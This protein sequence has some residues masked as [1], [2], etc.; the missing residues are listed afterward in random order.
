MRFSVWLIT[1]G[2][3]A[4][5]LSGCETRSGTY[6]TDAYAGAATVGPGA[7]DV[8]EAARL[9]TQAPDTYTRVAQNQPLNSADIIAMAQAGVGDDAIIAQIHASHSVYHLSSSDIIDTHDAGVSER[10]LQSMIDS[11]QTVASVV[12]APPPP[13]V[14]TPP[15]PTVEEA[16]P[17]PQVE[18]ENS[19]PGPGYVWVG[20]EWTWNG[21]WVWV[22]GHWTLP[23]PGEIAW[24][25][26]YWT[27]TPYG[28]HRVP[29]HWR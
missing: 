16:P 1:I 10:V 3:A 7:L 28:W 21:R 11:P 17:A 27:R 23:P 4:A 15:P 5:L 8:E 18:S 13:T 19:P 20:G 6:R 12:T 24:V 22:A 26:G 2:S 9:R 14:E 25:H 29:G